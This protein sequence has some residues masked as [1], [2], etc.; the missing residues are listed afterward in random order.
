MGINS[1]GLLELLPVITAAV[2]RTNFSNNTIKLMQI[3][4]I[5]F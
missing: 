4:E 5:K 3:I 1:T 2:Q